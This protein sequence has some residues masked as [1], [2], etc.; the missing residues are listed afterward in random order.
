[1]RLEPAMWDAFQEIADRE[2]QSLHNLTT[3]I[4]LRRGRTSLTSATR[5]F[6]LAYFK[7][8]AESG[9]SGGSPQ[10]GSGGRNSSSGP[11]GAADLLDRVFS[12]P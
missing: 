6:I 5:V 10:G 3:Q 9:D 11:T 8:M 1:M 7:Y 2:R 12:G 4:N